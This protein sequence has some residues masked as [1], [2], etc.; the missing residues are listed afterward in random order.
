MVGLALPTAPYC[1]ACPEQNLSKVVGP[2]GQNAGL[3]TFVD[4]MEKQLMHG[5]GPRVSIRRSAEVTK[6][7]P[8][9]GAGKDYL[10]YHGSGPPVAARRVILNLPP[11]PLLTL[12]R[13][14]PAMTAAASASPRNELGAL[15][16]SRGADAMKLYVHY[17]D[18]W[19][20]NALNLTV[21]YFNNS[22]TP[23]CTTSGTAV[24]QYAPLSGR[25]HDG[26]VECDLPASRC[27]GFLEAVYAY[28]DIAI[29]HYRP[30][31]TSGAEPFTVVERG[32]GWEA[33][34]LLDE[35]HASLVQL[36]AARLSAVGALEH[37]RSLRPQ[38]A[39]LSIFDRLSRGFGAGIHDWMRDGGDAASCSS[40]SEC[41]AVMPPRVLRPFGDE[42]VFVVNEAYGTRSGWC[43]GSLVMAENVVASEEFGLG[44]PEWIDRDVY[45]Q[46][47]IFNG[48]SVA[49]P[50]LLLSSARP[51]FRP[52]A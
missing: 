31:L 20:R 24:P 45:E 11:Q 44:R 48:T 13:A 19:W 10:L 49:E 33:E 41:Q 1:V 17:E 50:P 32:G 7:V 23:S 52:E 51:E 15:R 34:A 26:H 9:D 25:Y 8:P 27:R 42:P 5:F 35:L 37:V 29:A 38:L 14:S 16:H 36:H 3:S 28:D 47:V 4:A 18:A 46:H 30:Y 39:V 40:F 6:L 22:Y 21:G 43:E 12:L 2:G